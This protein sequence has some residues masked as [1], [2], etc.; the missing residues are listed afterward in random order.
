M[1]TI[2]RAAIIR[3]GKIY[4]GRRHYDIIKDMVYNHGC[5]PPIRQNE[6]GFVDNDGNFVN[7]IE[8]AT[9]ALENGQ[10]EKLTAPPLLYS[11]DLY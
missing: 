8:A 9:I 5:K 2:V 3:D 7:R 6:Q 11:E 10:V 4:E 1:K